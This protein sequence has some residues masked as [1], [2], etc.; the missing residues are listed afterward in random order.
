MLTIVNKGTS[1]TIVNKRLAIMILN[2]TTNFIRRYF[3]R[4]QSILKKIVFDKY[5]V[6]HMKTIMNVVLHEGKKLCGSKELLLSSLEVLIDKDPCP[7]GWF[8]LSSSPC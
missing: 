2:K 5:V 8:P 3:L 4:K 6:Q 1:L 7:S